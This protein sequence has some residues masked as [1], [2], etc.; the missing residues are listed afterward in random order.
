MLELKKSLRREGR[1]AKGQPAATKNG[2]AASLW[3]I[4]ESLSRVAAFFQNESRYSV[5]TENGWM[6]GLYKKVFVYEIIKVS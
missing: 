1:R 3:N 6:D 5:G 2:G 4:S